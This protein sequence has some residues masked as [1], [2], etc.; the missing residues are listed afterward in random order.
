VAKSGRKNLSRAKRL[1]SAKK[2]VGSYRGHIVVRGYKKWFGVTDLCAVLGLRMLGVDVP[3]ARLEQARRDEPSRAAGNARR[4]ERRARM[5][6]H[7]ERDETFAF[8]AGYTEG[9][10]P[11]GITWEEMESL[12]EQA[13]THPAPGRHASGEIPLRQRQSSR[14]REVDDEESLSF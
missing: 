8:I 5:A 11:Y 10:A 13:E 6:D 14:A 3:D 1:A 7:G 12:G 4:K 2:W 9:G